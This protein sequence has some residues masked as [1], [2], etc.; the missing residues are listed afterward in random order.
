MRYVKSRVRLSSWNDIGFKE[1]HAAFRIWNG[2]VAVEREVDINECMLIVLK[3]C[4]LCGLHDTFKD[5]LGPV[6]TEMSTVR[7]PVSIEEST[8]S[9]TTL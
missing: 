7:H 4:R 5:I 9:P 6:T 2:S 3:Q 1:L 8:S